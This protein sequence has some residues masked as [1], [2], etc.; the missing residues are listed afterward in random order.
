LDGAGDGGVH[1]EWEEMD[2]VIQ[3]GNKGII[4]PL[5]PC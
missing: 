3:V 2:V 1:G 5:E 4:S